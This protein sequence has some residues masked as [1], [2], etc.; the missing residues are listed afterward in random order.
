MPNPVLLVLIAE[1]NEIVREAADAM[2]RSGQ[3]ATIHIDQVVDWHRRSASYLSGSSP[4]L[5][6]QVPPLDPSQPYK[7][8]Y[9]AVTQ[10]LALLKSQEAAP[11]ANT[12]APG[13]KK[14]RRTHTEPQAESPPQEPSCFDVAIICAL[15]QLELEAIRRTGRWQILT[16]EPADPQT[17]YC[18]TLRSKAGNQIRLIAAAPNQMGLSAAGVLAAKVVWRFRP[19][20]VAMVGIAAGSSEEKQ[21]FGD[22]LVPDQTYDHGAAKT[23][24]KDGALR[25]SPN[26]NPIPLRPE[27]LTR[28]HEWKTDR[29]DLDAIARGWRAAKPRTHLEIHIGPLFSSPTVL[30][31]KLPVQDQL[32]NW[33]KL[34]GVEM[35]AHAVHR[36]CHD[37][38]RPPP[39]FVCMKAICDFA[40]NKDDAWQPYAAYTSSSLFLRFLKAEWERLGL[41]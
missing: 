6:S 32:L 38:V 36:A 21:G 31:A 19:K 5:A 2:D 9:V 25:V 30:D 14:Q 41:R 15:P 29:R 20:L 33:R 35:E 17:Y 40:E 7:R 16:A 12:Q 22:I 8:I 1:G 37:T 3:T 26:P 10:T 24:A 27:I 4:E 11:S 18:S 34:I 23:R 28:V 39:A 13:T